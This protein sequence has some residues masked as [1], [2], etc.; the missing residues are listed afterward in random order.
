M[1][2]RFPGYYCGRWNV[3]PQEEIEARRSDLCPARVVGTE[4][5]VEM[6]VK[7]LRM[8]VEEV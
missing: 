2:E 8:V 5:T 3:K 6:M 4:E 1:K 7:Y